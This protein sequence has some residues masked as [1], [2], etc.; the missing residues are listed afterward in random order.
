MP[1][2]VF[3]FALDQRHQPI[4]QRNGRDDEL[5][6]DVQRR[7][8]EVGVVGHTAAIIACAGWQYDAKG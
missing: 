6:V 4:S 7:V 5:A 2:V 1:A 3:D 8:A